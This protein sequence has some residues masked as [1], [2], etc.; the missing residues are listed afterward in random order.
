[1]ALPSYGKNGWSG[2]D[3]R[4]LYTFRDKRTGSVTVRPGGDARGVG[5]ECDVRVATKAEAEAHWQNPLHSGWKTEHSSMDR[6]EGTTMAKVGDRYYNSGDHANNPEEMVVVADV[7]GG[8]FKLRGTKSGRETTV[9]KELLGTDRLKKM[10]LTEVCLPDGTEIKTD[11]S[12]DE[13][14][15]G[16]FA[17]YAI[18]A[19]CPYCHKKVS[20]SAGSLGN[21]R[22]PGGVCDGAGKRV[23]ALE[24]GRAVLAFSWTKPGDRVRYKGKSGPQWEGTVLKPT[25]QGSLV[26]TVRWDSGSESDVSQANVDVIR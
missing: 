1:M 6:S 4:T 7:G 19:Q 23:Q 24:Q 8:Y 18:S 20:M 9:P 3:S 26:Y 14:R 13:A 21:H 5:P 12:G 17:L 11:P 15:A 10:D 25:K 22:A 16:N 2:G